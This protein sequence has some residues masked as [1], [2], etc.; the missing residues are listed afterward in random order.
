MKRYC[1]F[2][3]SI[4]VWGIT[5]LKVKVAKTNMAERTVFRSHI[6]TPDDYDFSS[7][8]VG[9]LVHLRINGC[10][11]D[12]KLLTNL[13]DTTFSWCL[14]RREH[15]LVM[16]T[17]NAIDFAVAR[18]KSVNLNTLAQIAV[19]VA[20]EA[21]TRIMPGITE[22]TINHSRLSKPCLCFTRHLAK[23]EQEM[24][25]AY[26]TIVPQRYDDAKGWVDLVYN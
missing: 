7:D 25:I 26:T 10:V 3:F 1:N 18:T 13:Q 8:E 17:D 11:R 21:L 5:L 6:F 9:T 4:F 14:D 19:G 16:A 22:T 20:D 24:V 23:A 12:L 2:G 15:F